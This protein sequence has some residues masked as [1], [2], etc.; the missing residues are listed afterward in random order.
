MDKKNFRKDLELI[1]GLSILSVILFHLDIKYFNYGFLGVDVFFLISGYV[2]TQSLQKD[3]NNNIYSFRLFI[4]KRFFRLYPALITCIILSTIFFLFFGDI[5]EISAI[6]TQ[7]LTSLFSIQNLFLQYLRVDYFFENNIK[8]FEH[9]W[10]IS[11]EIQIY[12]FIGLIYFFLYKKKIDLF[13]F[14]FIIILFLSFYIYFNL[15]HLNENYFSL[16]IRLFEFFLGSLSYFLN[17]KI[18]NRY[19]FYTNLMIAGLLIINILKFQ[20]NYF[21]Y[22]LLI[23]LIL[24]NY[25]SFFKLHNQIYY[26]PLNYLGKISYSVYLYHLPLSFFYFIYLDTQLNEIINSLGYLFILFLISLISY[27]FIEKKKS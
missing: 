2:I 15:K 17:N 7:S 23:C 4:K 3:I 25:L 12:I 22:I 1:R 10:S 11:A 16:I 26:A 5:D 9:L 27:N 21:S 6:F 14:T 8:F 19:A 18:K 13:N 24:F 20:N